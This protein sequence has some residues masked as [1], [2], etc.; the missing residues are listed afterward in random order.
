VPLTHPG[1]FA[2]YETLAC[3][4][5]LVLQAP[6]ELGTSFQAAGRLSGFTVKRRRSKSADSEPAEYIPGGPLAPGRRW[7]RCPDPTAGIPNTGLSLRGISE[8]PNFLLQFRRQLRRPLLRSRKSLH[9]KA[10]RDSDRKMPELAVTPLFKH[11]NH[12]GPIA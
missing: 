12:Y 3:S 2:G 7:I 4:L 9:P 6:P 11:L 1:G 5:R 10:F 8:H